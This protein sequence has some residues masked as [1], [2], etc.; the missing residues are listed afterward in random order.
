MTRN[1]RIVLLLPIV[2][3]IVAASC[4]PAKRYEELNSRYQDALEASRKAQQRQD[5]M[6][7][8]LNELGSKHNALTQQLDRLL[9]DS[10]T[11]GQALR[12]AQEENNKLQRNYA[13]LERMQKTL[14]EGNQ[15]ETTKMLAEM[16][17]MQRELQQREDAVK[18]LEQELHR[19]KNALAAIETEQSQTRRHL[20]SLRV[21]LQATSE[22]LAQQNK[23]YADLQRAMA[24][25]DSATAALKDRV[26]KALFGFQGKGLTV[27]EK[28]GRV[29]VSLEEQ[30]MFKSGSY[31]VDARGQE[32]IKQLIPVLEQNTEVN[33][34]VEGHTDDVPMR[35]SGPIADN[36]D[37]SVKRATSIVKLLING[38]TIAPARISAAGRAEYVPL[39]PEKTSQARQQNRRTE[40]ILTPRLEELAALLGQ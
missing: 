27:H 18:A 31:T 5:S 20:D 23:A 11:Q 28:D 16:Q 2:A 35:G 22:A 37:L 32:A 14:V 24:R 8:A 39:N 29:Y 3:L 33:I 7:V 21:G 6:Q 40:I 38:S 34:L 12:Q 15:R 10:L 17:R 1:H 26:A 4:V 19:K 25:K 36:W 9:Q 30:L 13:D